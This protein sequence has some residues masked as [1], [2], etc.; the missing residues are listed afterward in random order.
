MA[1]ANGNGTDLTVGEGSALLGAD[2]LREQLNLLEQH[3][4]SQTAAVQRAMAR[5]MAVRQ[6]TS[7]GERA[8]TDLVAA[9]TSS[10]YKAAASASRRLA[11]WE[12]RRVLLL[13]HG[14]E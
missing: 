12:A 9:L 10:D 2:I 5:E 14:A 8:E 4:R 1:K 13:F 7:E 3:Q 6:A 11:F